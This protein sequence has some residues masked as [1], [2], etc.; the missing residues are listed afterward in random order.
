MIRR[1]PRA[2]RTDTLFPYTTL[3]RSLVVRR[4]DQLHAALFHRLDDPAEP[5][6]AIGIV[7]IEDGDAAV[8]EV[9][10]QMLDPGLGLLVV[11]RAH[12]DDVA[13]L[14]RAQEA[15]A[16]EGADEGHAR[17]GGD[18]LGQ[19]GRASGRERVGQYV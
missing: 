3:F 17:L 15:R 19:I 12:V 13:E 10:G 5:R 18:R 11:A 16:G 14:R 7:L 9:F 6:A 8:A 2:T 1:P 4:G